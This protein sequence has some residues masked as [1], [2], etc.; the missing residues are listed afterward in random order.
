MVRPVVLQGASLQ[1]LNRLQR[2]FPFE[3]QPFKAVAASLGLGESQAIERLRGLRQR[4]VLGRIGAV[5]NPG[6]GGAAAL[7]ALAVPPARLAEVAQLV[8][9]EPTVN[10]N[11]EREHDW[12]LWY[13]LTAGD[14]RRVRETA[15]RLA[16]Q[17]G[18]P[19]LFLPMVR[20][21]RI[22]LGFDLCGTHAP[23][24][25]APFVQPRGTPVA[26]AERP[27]A[28][29]AE[30][31]LALVPR[32]YDLWAA[33]LGWPLEA[34]LQLLRR[35]QAGGTLR[36]FGAV[37]RHHEAGFGANAMTVVQ[38]PAA[39]VDSLGAAL[40]AQPGVTL[41]YQR[42][43]DT[44][45]PYNLYFM[46]HGRERAVVQ[47]LIAQALARSGAHRHPHATLFSGRRFKQTGGRYFTDAAPVACP[48]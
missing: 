31:G 20:A 35:W 5:W 34:V 19:S 17:A 23:A 38:A 36:R 15:A 37:V 27:L 47:H 9:D 43:P 16:Q 21:Y 8:S 48:A 45:W 39:Q 41:A 10:H 33:E 29:L 18:T 28:A 4:G 2:D 7:C 42:V 12:S 22:D 14:A 30:Q 32:P 44:G 6:A 11:Y 24:L 3:P 46:V 40:A 25:A 13:V 26:A 1:L